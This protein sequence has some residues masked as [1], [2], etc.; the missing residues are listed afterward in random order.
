MFE[1][2]ID[3][4][5]SLPSWNGQG[6]LIIIYAYIFCYSITNLIRKWAEH[7]A[8]CFF[9]NELRLWSTQGFLMRTMSI[10]CVR[11]VFSSQRVSTS[12]VLCKLVV[13]MNSGTPPPISTPE[14]AEPQ[15]ARAAAGV[16][17]PGLDHRCW[18]RV[19]CCDEQWR[20]AP[21]DVA[22]VQTR[23]PW[24]ASSTKDTA[25]SC[26]VRRTLQDP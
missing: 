1:N 15:G 22:G 19:L 26:G 24:V 3:K 12:N 9:Y 7:F 13:N 8:A 20:A 18:R 11:Y 2:N 17:S 21:F 25:G 4:Q 5:V 14:T 23:G 6:I 10:S 16:P